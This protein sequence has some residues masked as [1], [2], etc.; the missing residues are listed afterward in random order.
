[1]ERH[2]DRHRHR[3]MSAEDGPRHHTKVGARELG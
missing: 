2:R 3:E 1:M